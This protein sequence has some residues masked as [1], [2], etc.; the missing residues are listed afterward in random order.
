[1]ARFLFSLVALAGAAVWAFS[2][3]QDV[4]AGPLAANAANAADPQSTSLSCKPQGPIHV[5]LIDEG[6]AGGRLDLAL[7]L[8]PLMDL[9]V[10]DWELELPQGAVLLEGNLGGSASTERGKETHGRVAILLPVDS[11]FR[12]V[13][14]VAHGVFLAEDLDGRTGEGTV[15]GSAPAL[16]EEPVVVRSTL[17]WGEPE[18]DAPQTF[19]MDSRSGQLSAAV[20]MPSSHKEGR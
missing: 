13:T 12:Q 18:P 1:M 16:I 14:L 9:T 5:Q 8:R 11:S 3:P 19:T 10:L 2:A 4:S 17:S 20:I 15:D 6:Q 7:S